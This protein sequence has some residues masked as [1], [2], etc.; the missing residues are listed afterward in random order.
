MLEILSL[1][2]DIPLVSSEVY[3]TGFLFIDTL[4]I[5][6]IGFMDP[7]E[8]FRVVFLSYNGFDTLSTDILHVYNRIERYIPCILKEI[9]ELFLNI[10]DN[11]FF[12]LLACYIAV[13][14]AFVTF[15]A[16]VHGEEPKTWVIAFVYFLFFVSIAPLWWW[17]LNSPLV[18]SKPSLCFLFFIFYLFFILFFETKN[19]WTKSDTLVQTYK[20][21]WTF[22]VTSFFFVQIKTLLSDNIRNLKSLIIFPWFL[23]LFV[24][25]LFSNLF[26]LIPFSYTVTSTLITTFYLSISYFISINIIG[27]TLHKDNFTQVFSPEGIPLAITPFLLLVE[28]ISYFA[29]VASIA[30][31][32]FANLMSGHTLLHIL[33][34]AAWGMLS[35]EIPYIFS[36]LLPAIIIFLISALEFLIGVMQAFVFVILMSIYFNDLLVLH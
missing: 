29:R 26:G 20:R 11:D 12:T 4:K 30:I 1:Y 6:F 5:D 2:L 25:I 3:A 27:I 31:R 22:Y 24:F 15:P 34:G 17:A 36:L 33:M 28:I 21:L 19:W 18:I 10:R 35:L 7:L 32:L 16:R 23:I 9:V 14:I 13:V 8:Q